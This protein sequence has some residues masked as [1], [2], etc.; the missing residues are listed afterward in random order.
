MRMGCFVV[1]IQSVRFVPSI[2]A[3][4][5][6]H[7]APSSDVVRIYLAFIPLS[8]VSSVFLFARRLLFASVDF[9]RGCVLDLS[10]TFDR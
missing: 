3:D 1:A 7:H 2:K 8:V 10:Y 5:H 4:H 9:G 6:H